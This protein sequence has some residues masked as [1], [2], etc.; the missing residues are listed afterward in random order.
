VRRD[1]QGDLRRVASYRLAGGQRGRLSFS[2][3]QSVVAPTTPGAGQEDEHR[4][5]C[6]T[7]SEPETASPGCSAE[8]LTPPCEQSNR[9]DLHGVWAVRET[10]PAAT[11]R[12]H[13]SAQCRMNNRPG[14]CR[15]SFSRQHRPPPPRAEP[16]DVTELRVFVLHDIHGS[17]PRGYLCRRRATTTGSC[18]G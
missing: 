12:D 11:A 1:R 4:D 13:P 9:S 14:R 16:S 6:R 15:A 2:G 10:K 18:L 7:T 8:P 5:A 17:R 3:L